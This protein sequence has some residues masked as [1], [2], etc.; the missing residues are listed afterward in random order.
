MVRK[1]LDEGALAGK[2][3][4]VPELAN[5]VLADV[6]KNMVWCKPVVKL[7][8]SSAPSGFLLADALIV[9][10]K[11]FKVA[12][13]LLTGYSAPSRI[14]KAIAEASWDDWVG[15]S[16]SCL[17]SPLAPNGGIGHQCSGPSYKQNLRCRVGIPATRIGQFVG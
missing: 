16:G 14:A 13:C 4:D 7:Y 15:D 2:L 3:I 10:D 1:L 12:P 8:P 6:Q 17:W 11:K 9:L 5:P